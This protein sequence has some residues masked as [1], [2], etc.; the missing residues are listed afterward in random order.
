MKFISAGHNQKPGPNYDPG[1]VS[2]N[3]IEAIET[4]RIR[5]RVIQILEQK[6]IKDFARDMDGESLNQYLKRIKPGNASVV[7]E[8]HFNASSDSRATGVEV[9]V[10]ADADRLDKACAKDFCD[11]TADILGLKNRGVKSEADSHRGK[12]G[13]MREQGIVFLVEVCFIS[14][15]SDMKAYDEQFENLCQ[16]YA[17]LFQKWDLVVA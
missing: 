11:E 5:N 6:G 3:R 9:L 4:A 10:G 17:A 16:L 1:A 8:F 2:G 13:L 15:P 14:N 7:G 12:L